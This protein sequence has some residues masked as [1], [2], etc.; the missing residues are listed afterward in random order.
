VDCAGYIECFFPAAVADSFLARL[1][2]AATLGFEI[3]G[4]GGGRWVCQ[5]GGGRVLDI[6]RDTPERAEVTYR[7]DVATFAAV[8]TGHEMPQA[9]FFARRIEIAGSVEKGLKL[10]ALFGRFVR[11]S[12]YRPRPVEEH[13]AATH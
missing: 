8:V 9:A 3:R 11:E 10:A 6:C 7:M 13:H 12:P 1:S 2:I 5:F 4:P